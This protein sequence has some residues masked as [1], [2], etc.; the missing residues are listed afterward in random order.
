[1]LD[2][3]LPLAALA[4]IPCFSACRDI[5]GETACNTDLPFYFGLAFIISHGLELGFLAATAQLPLM[6]L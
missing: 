5:L 6:L 3:C 4:R 1:M 2:H